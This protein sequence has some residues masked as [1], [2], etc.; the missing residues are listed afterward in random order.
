M[1]TFGKTSSSSVHG[2]GIVVAGI[3]AIIMF[4]SIATAEACSQC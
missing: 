4:T 2:V 3:A 1:K